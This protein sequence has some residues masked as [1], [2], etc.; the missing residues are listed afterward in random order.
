M[1]HKSKAEKTN[2]VPF[3]LFALFHIGF[4]RMG[5]FI[6]DNILKKRVRNIPRQCSLLLYTQQ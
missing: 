6:D 4:G 5:S 1:S 3:R 2:A